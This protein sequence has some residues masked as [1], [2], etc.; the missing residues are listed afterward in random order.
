MT[1]ARRSFFAGLLLLAAAAV[2]GQLVY[3]PPAV[4]SGFVVETL[5]EA[6]S[7][8]VGL[9]LL[10]DG[11]A[12]V[13]ERGSGAIKVWAGG[14]GAAVV[15][16]VPGVNSGAFERGL[17]AIAVDPQWP[18]RPYVYVWFDS[19]GTANMR[20]AMFTV[21]GDLS[22]PASTNLTLGAQYD[23]LTDTPDVAAI[24]NGGS[25]RFGPD[26]MLYV[27]I[28]DDGNPC[29]AQDVNSGVGCLFRMDVSAL[30]GPGQ[31]PPPKS[32]LTP[33]GNPFPGPTD[34]ARLTWCHG[35]RNPFRFHVDPVTGGI[36][37]A[38]V[39]AALVDEIDESTAGGENFGWP[40]L[41]ANQYGLPCNGQAPP[42]VHPITTVAHSGA[43]TA[44]MSFG[45]YRNAPNGAFSFGAPYEGDYFY[46]EYYSGLVRRLQFNGIGW[47]PAP[48]A[49]G[50]PA[51]NAWGVGFQSVVDTALGQDGALY[52]VK[53]YSSHL[54]GALGRIRGNP[55][56]QFLTVVSGDHQAGNAGRPLTHPLVVRLAD[57]AGAPVVG[58]TVTFSVSAGGG[59]VNPPS[60]T[61]DAAGHASTSYTLAPAY[62][63]APVVAA[64]AA[65]TSVAL[66]Q[67]VWRGISVVYS[68]P[69]LS[70][71]TAEVRHSETN[72]PFTLAWE[73]P[74]PGPYLQTPYGDVWTSVLAPLP[75][76]QLFDGLGLVGP[77]NPQFKT[78]LSSPFWS[79][80]V[81]GLP[82]FGG[83]PVLFQAYAIDTA[84]LPAPE[85]FMISNA[86]VVTI[87]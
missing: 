81:T 48:A 28:G 77:P 27:S 26:G 59:S 75:S 50:Q 31:G 55:S 60:A 18:V 1:G 58:Q 52:F 9:A 41:E 2:Q 38:D 61:T 68:L 20:L 53:Q 72:S 23:V 39:G 16:V 36:H 49:P 79:I 29:A 17:L 74:A 56:A 83:I 21:F 71:V 22:N 13:I 24:H 66:F 51:A 33:V 65:G 86:Q 3:V 84:L 64:T 19:M 6:L 73:L 4:P 69:S 70:S 62:S 7:E 10:P 76:L 45:R 15:G 37:I 43:P 35:L 78:G 63:Q 42:T 67:V 11:R 12:L 25:L 87:L 5:T 82:P 47:I 32:L 8:P 30:P 80:S 44:V 40:W 46:C 85:S 14:L 57:A 54:A 34:N